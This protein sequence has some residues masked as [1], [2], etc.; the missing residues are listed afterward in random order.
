[1]KLQ[2]VS[3]AIV[4][5]AFV[6]LAY[7]Q[8]RFSPPP[9]KQIPTRDTI[10]GVVITD[11][12]RWLEDKD[13]PEVKEWSKAQHNYTIEYIKRATKQ[14]PGL[15]EEIRSYL[16]RDYVSAPFFKAKREF[17][18]ARR[19][20]DQQS[21]L[22]TRLDGR[23]QLVFDPM[24]ID[25]SGKTAISSFV[26]NKD[27]NKAAVGVQTR[28]NEII[29][30]YFIDTRTGKEIAPPLD[31]VY[32][33]SWCRDEKF[34]YVTYRSAEDIK[35]QVPLKTFLHRIG[36]ETT[37]DKF[38]FAP[39]DAKDFASIWDD[40]DTDLTF[41][42]EGDFYSNT[43]KIQKGNS[44]PLVIFQSD[45]YRATPLVRNNRVYFFT[46]YEAPNYK[47]MVADFENPEF[48]HW[49]PLIPEIDVPIENYEVTTDYILVHTKRD[50]LSQ[51]LVY[52]LDGKFL[53]KMEL[54]ELGNIGS[55][56]YHKETN[57][58]YISLMTFTS[59]SKLYKLDGK[60]LKWTF[61]FQDKSPIN[62][63][64]IESKQVFYTSKDGT[65]IP[66]FIVYKKGLKLDG[67]NPTL[68]YGYGGFNVGMSPHYV[69]VTASFVNRGGVYA[70]ACL[71]GGDEYGENWHRQG[72]LFN[73]QNVFDD[74]IS[75]AEYLIA[76][77]YTNPQKLA[78]KGGSNGGLLIGAVVTQRP[79]LFCAGI[80]GVPLLD[81][82]RYHKFLIA[83]YWIPEYGDPDKEADFRNLL[84][85]SPY[86]NVRIGLSIPTLLIKAGENDTRVDPLHAKKF[87]ALLQNSEWQT[88]PILLYIDFESGHGS[89]QSIE[90]Q[91]NN[92]EIEW[93]WLMNQLGM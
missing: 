46:N 51:L 92:I 20:G 89:G 58:V 88:N 70:V 60:S 74:F 4:F 45:K 41:V 11:F 22:F 82:I 38:L 31:N 33:L 24:K 13:N 8:T 7:A 83:R 16:D 75:A 65:K 81:M 69:G 15:H 44:N 47:I 59:P 71:R 1:M 52:S 12:Y 93:Q 68:L 87:A 49:K 53:K 85:Y 10:F 62:T 77:K 9:T 43:L 6:H 76:E 2:Y 56:S 40:E 37:S 78:I 28:G 23:E 91:V 54:P 79:D 42:S 3:R 18:Y 61:V 34:V 32:S 14:I 72:M 48:E 5:L 57:C 27:A 17:F 90:Q 19:Q 35:K 50:V 29:R 25:S 80:C 66:M 30:Y 36:E 64:Q 86:H 84:K 73:K 55:M 39:K 26:L 21:K 67:N 63:D